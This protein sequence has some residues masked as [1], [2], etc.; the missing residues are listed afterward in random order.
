MCLNHKSQNFRNFCF[1][2]CY[3]TNLLTV[4]DDRIAR[5]LKTSGEEQRLFK[6]WYTGLLYKLKLNV[7]MERCFTEAA[8]RDVL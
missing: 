4:I 1:I 2:S 3:T 6:V 7:V 5:V 8:T